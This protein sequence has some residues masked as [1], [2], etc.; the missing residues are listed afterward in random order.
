MD[1]ENQGVR[2]SDR[3]DFP[4]LAVKI[5][6]APVLATTLLGC[7]EASVSAVGTA[8]T[9]SNPPAPPPLVA[10]AGSV[11]R[12]RLDQAL[13]TGRSRSGDR[14]SGVLDSPL[15]ADG[16]QVLEKGTVVHGRVMISHPSGRLKG[17]A[18]LSLTLD[19]C[20][21][22]G[23]E[24]ALSVNP[25]TRESGRHRKRNWT[26]IGGGSGT[27]ALIGGLVGGPVGAL[28]GAGSGA[29]AGTAGAAITGKK[30]VGMPAESLAGFTLKSP[31]VI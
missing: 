8:N 12:V 20:E 14:F 6:L 31:L 24:I 18:V 3:K 9:V 28:A 29:A 4:A 15:Y 2:Q 16:T 27:G 11:L 1:Q 25:V 21:V 23:R 13:D 26:W 10:P 30:Q 7:H 5:L 22:G 17:R 19:S